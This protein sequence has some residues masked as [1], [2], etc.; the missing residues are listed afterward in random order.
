LE[1]GI[2]EL[3]GRKSGR[4]DQGGQQIR[5]QEIMGIR[6]FHETLIPY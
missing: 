4:K 3:G 5:D 2:R 1:S 6:E